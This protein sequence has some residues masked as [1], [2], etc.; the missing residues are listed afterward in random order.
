MQ[1]CTS[2]FV[3]PNK[4]IRILTIQPTKDTKNLKG[5]NMDFVCC[6]KIVFETSRFEPRAVRKQTRMNPL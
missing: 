6:D 2:T 5:K 3:V 1:L 4:A